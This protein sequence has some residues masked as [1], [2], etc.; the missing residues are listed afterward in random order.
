[1]LMRC[2]SREGK[3]DSQEQGVKLAEAISSSRSEWVG[4]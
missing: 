3:M 2:S 4:N 1:M